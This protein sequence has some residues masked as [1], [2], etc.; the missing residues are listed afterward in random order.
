MVVVSSIAMAILKSLIG[1]LITAACLIAYLAMTSEYDDALA[2]EGKPGRVLEV[3]EDGVRYEI[4]DPGSP[5]DD[6]G[7]G[8]VGPYTD[9]DAPESALATLRPGNPVTIK[10]GQLE[11]SLSRPSPLLLFGVFFGLLIA[12]WAFIGPMLERRALEDAQSDPIRLITFMVKKTRNTQIIAGAITLLMGLGIVVVPFFDDSAGTGGLIFLVALG[13]VAILAALFM[14]SKAWTL[15][16][17]SR[18]PVMRAILEQPQRICWVYQFTHE[19]N[20]VPNYHIF[21][22]LEDGKKLEFSLAQIDPSSLLMA[23]KERLPHA[24]FGY[25]AERQQLFA[26]APADFRSQAPTL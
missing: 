6:D 3:T 15:R 19:V 2:S 11:V 22:H 24:I 21:V 26:R 1:V 14:F 16:D 20:G 18:A 10:K 4:H 13:A 17:P 5:W 8:W 25:S 7:D 9:E 23:L 12:A